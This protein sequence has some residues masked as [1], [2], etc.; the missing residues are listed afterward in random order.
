[1]FKGCSKLT[2]IYMPVITTVPQH[3]F[4]G[5]GFKQINGMEW[6]EDANM[7]YLPNLTDISGAQVFAE[8]KN[9]L[10]VY[11][12]KITKIG[13]SGFTQCTKLQEAYIDKVTTFSGNDFNGCTNLKYV[14]APELTIVSTQSF[15]NCASLEYVSFEKVTKIRSSS[16][17]G[18]T[19]LK[20]VYLPKLSSDYAT[21]TNKF[22]GCKNLV[23]LY[24]PNLPASSIQASWF[25]GC[26]NLKV[27]YLG[28]LTNFDY[29]DGI[30]SLCAIFNGN[31][32]TSKEVSMPI[33]VKGDN[34]ENYLPGLGCNRTIVENFSTEIVFADINGKMITFDELFG[35]PT[36]S[37]IPVAVY[38]KATTIDGELTLI[39]HDDIALDMEETFTVR[40]RI[41]TLDGA[42]SYNVVQVKDYA[43]YGV[44]ATAGTLTFGDGIKVVGDYILDANA[45]IYNVDYNLIER[46]GAL[47][48]DVLSTL[49]GRH[50]V[51]F[52]QENTFSNNGA[53]SEISFDSLQVL[54]SGAFY[55][56]IGLTGVRFDSVEYVDGGDTN[57]VFGNCENLTEVSFGANLQS[58]T[59]NV[60]NGCIRLQYFIV[61]NNSSVVTFSSAT[62]LSLPSGAI[63]MVSGNLLLDYNSSAWYNLPCYD[64]SGNQSGTLTIES[65]QVMQEV[66]DITY[67]FDYLGDN[68]EI[69]YISTSNYDC[70]TLQLPTYYVVDVDDV[71]PVVSISRSAM[72]V[73]NQ[74]TNLETLTLPTYLR[75]FDN[76]DLLPVSLK[77]F[78]IDS[79]STT[80]CVDDGVLYT[81]GGV[82]VSYPAGKLDEEYTLP[83]SVT[84]IS[85]QAF[86][87]T[88]YL[89]VIWMNERSMPPQFVGEDIFANSS[90]EYI[91]IPNGERDWYTLAV[92]TD[93]KVETLFVEEDV[94]IE[95]IA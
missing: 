46:V 31:L 47:Q 16:F 49:I 92:L 87:N 86:V 55:N 95:N 33:I 88:R 9:L 7:A 83:N 64:A 85:K 17:S 61:E 53:L 34:A 19:S 4:Y 20:S 35:D 59:G 68:M 82:L 80:F 22:N 54:P 89:K 37:R 28:N 69:A 66:D 42:I 70:T 23:W 11:L 38:Q 18:C 14:Y 75:Y 36:V 12:D 91:V 26:T 13:S 3:C 51:E 93:K 48:V 5:C 40:D 8:C 6:T 50:V 21:E 79:D 65:F 78:V 60:F 72:Q 41:T 76:K 29:V 24:L 67:Y 52:S 32:T 27:V 39:R 71:I 30:A 73:I 44:G 43:M 45:K 25:N 94:Y 90:V 74:F 77:E 1:T 63:L 58:I 81:Y 57:A 15:L 56:C 10:K 2:N 84:I 62:E